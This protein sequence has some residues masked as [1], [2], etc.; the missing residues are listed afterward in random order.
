VAGIGRGQLKVL[1][2]HI[3]RKRTI[4]E[5]YKEHLETTKKVH[6]MPV[7][8]GVYPNYW[9]SCVTFDDS[10]TP[11]EVYARFDEERISARP[12]WKPMHLQ[13][14]YRHCDFITTQSE[15]SMGEELFGVGLC[16][17]SDINMDK[18]ELDRIITT[19]GT[20]TLNP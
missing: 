4:F 7:P 1:D 14:F 11:A 9:L 16:L 8:V 17:P 12:V 2:R 18:M 3:V 15:R 5:Y 20:I 13:P 19:I 6:M 10:H